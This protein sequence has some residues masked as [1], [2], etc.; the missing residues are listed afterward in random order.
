MNFLKKGA[1]R[2]ELRNTH[3]AAEWANCVQG[4][5]RQE[6]DSRTVTIFGKSMI[7]CDQSDQ[8]KKEYLD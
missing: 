3:Y 1:F 6:G 7:D 2:N 4:G 5:I 8:Y